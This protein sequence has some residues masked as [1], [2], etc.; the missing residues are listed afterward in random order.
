MQQLKRTPP[1][2]GDHEGRAPE[3]PKVWPIGKKN[4]SLFIGA[5]QRCTMPYDTRLE[6]YWFPEKG[7]ERAMNG[8]YKFR[9]C[10]FGS[11]L[12]ETID[13]VVWIW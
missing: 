11:F 2:K 10:H 5:E 13:Y 7:I 9:G 4:S 3:S 1:A 12:G 6:R 8:D